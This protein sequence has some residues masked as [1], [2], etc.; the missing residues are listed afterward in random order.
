MIKRGQREPVRF[1]EREKRRAEPNLLRLAAW[2]SLAGFATLASG[3]FKDE[4]LNSECDIEQ[5]FLSLSDPGA[6]F[7]RDNDTLVSLSSVETNAVFHVREDA[8]LS[9]IAPH[10][11]L[12]EGA[13]IVPAD[14]EPHDFSAGPVTYVVTSADGRYSRSYSVS[15]V[16][17]ERQSENVVY[18]FESAYAV[19]S[20]LMSYYAWTDITPS[21]DSLFNWATANPAF[22]LAL[23]GRKDVSFDDFPT[24]VLSPGR[25]GNGV[26]LTTMSTGAFGSLFGKPIAAGNLFIGSFASELAATKP[27]EATR[28]GKPTTLAPKS[29]EG[30]YKYKAGDVFTDADMKEIDGRTDECS[31]YAVF[32]R[33]EDADGNEVVLNGANV[34]TSPSLVA[35]AVV[36]DLA[37]CDEWTLFHADFVYDAEVDPDVLARKGY[38]LAMVFSSS[39]GGDDFE[40]A[41]GSTLCID[42]VSLISDAE[43]GE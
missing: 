36:R 42:S 38:S 4:P 11:T 6:L 8:D 29:F 25:S 9:S 31:I 26:R 35:R 39:A 43:A 20:G 21:G 12:S 23:A 32:Y 2:L 7:F 30:Y 5:V 27:L 24:S 40:G 19:K 33:N 28:F 34:L 1:A 13:S 14:G 41:V 18:E 17:P 3:C 15:F 16:L 22:V 37:Q 10:F